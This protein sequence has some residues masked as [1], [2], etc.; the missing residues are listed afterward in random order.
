MFPTYEQ[1]IYSPRPNSP[2]LDFEQR[3]SP[4]D[5]NMSSTARYSPTP[6]QLPQIQYQN[7]VAVLQDQTSPIIVHDNTRADINFINQ[8]NSTQTTQSNVND[9]EDYHVD[10]T[11]DTEELVS[12]VANEL[13]LMQSNY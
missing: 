2:L 6:V 8:Q 9:V 11:N 4:L 7:S 3:V 12:N 13:I 5:P 1:V 10:N